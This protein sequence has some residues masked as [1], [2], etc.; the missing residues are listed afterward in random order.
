GTARRG[1]M[2]TEA[3]EAAPSTGEPTNREPSP[4]EGQAA[5]G[6]T[7]PTRAGRRTP[8][9]GLWR[10]GR[11]V[12][13]VALVG[14][15]A[16]WFWLES[17][18]EVGQDAI[19]GWIEQRRDREAEQALR[20]RLER[21]PHDG[22]SRIL[23]ARLLAQ[24]QDKL[25]CARELHRIPFWWPDRAR[26]TL[27]EAGAFEDLGRMADA[28]AAWKLLVEDD[29]LHP[30]DPKVAGVASHDLLELYAVEGRWEDAVQLIWKRY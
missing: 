6:R 12:L 20:E 28:E 8:C 30:V 1:A 26:W 3:P 25:A 18:P 9:H 24:R 22:A 19:A 13:L 10:L 7:R 15:N 2:T 17:R 11:W 29:P 16:W 4:P 5:A 14:L 27:I 23:L 21:S